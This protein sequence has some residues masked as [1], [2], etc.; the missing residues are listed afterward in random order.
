M[1]SY[2]QFRLNERA[3]E[4]KRLTQLLRETLERRFCPDAV[5]S[6]AIDNLDIEITM[7]SRDLKEIGN[8]S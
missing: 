6:A 5:V 1:E 4:L 3:N 7:L 2:Q 8:G